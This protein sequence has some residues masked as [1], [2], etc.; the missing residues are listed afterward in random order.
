MEYKHQQMSLTELHMNTKT[1]L[2]GMG[3]KELSKVTLENATMTK[4]CKAKDKNKC[5]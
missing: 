3:R 2:K 5:A 4:Y 1:S